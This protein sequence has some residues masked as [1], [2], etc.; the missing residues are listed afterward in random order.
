MA[1]LVLTNKN[2]TKNYSA[3]FRS[4]FEYLSKYVALE[5]TT[6]DSWKGIVHDLTSIARPYQDNSFVVGL[7]SAC[8]EEIERELCPE[9]AET[10]ADML[11]YT[12]TDMFRHTMLQLS[13]NEREEVMRSLS[14]IYTELQAPVR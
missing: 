7:L 13:A 14:G 2:G 5:S 11:K 6:E 3:M 9:S 10:H 4:A 1:K 8:L 12:L